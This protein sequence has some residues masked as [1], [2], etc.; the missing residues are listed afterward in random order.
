MSVLQCLLYLQLES[1][2]GNYLREFASTF[3]ASRTIYSGGVQLGNN[4]L[5]VRR[6]QSQKATGD[7]NHTRFTPAHAMVEC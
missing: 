2:G 4:Q 3:W 5:H 7:G 6:S 1:V